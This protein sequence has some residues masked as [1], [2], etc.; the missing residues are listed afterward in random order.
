MKKLSVMISLSIAQLSVAATLEQLAGSYKVTHDEIPV[1]N[2]VKISSNGLIKLTE[3]SQYGIVECTGNGRISNNVLT[4][5]LS[6]ENGDTFTQSI[7]LKGIRSFKKFEA[8]VLSSLYGVELKMKF[9][10]L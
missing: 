1:V 8:K 4:S 10:R 9:E 5:T 3:S 6:C 2:I 7:N